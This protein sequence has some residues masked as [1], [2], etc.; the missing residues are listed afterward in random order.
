MR[1]PEQSVM[2]QDL[3]HLKQR[4]RPDGRS[5]KLWVMDHAGAVS[6]TATA[7]FR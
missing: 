4:I 7:E 5:A 2:T 6:T 3:E 1:G